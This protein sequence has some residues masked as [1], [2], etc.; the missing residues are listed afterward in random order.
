MFSSHHCWARDRKRAIASTTSCFFPLQ[1]KFDG[2]FLCIFLEIKLY[3]IPVGAGR[4]TD[5]QVVTGLE[6]R[7]THASRRVKS[8]VKP[9]CMFEVGSPEG[10]KKK[11]MRREMFVGWQASTRSLFTVK[12]WRALFYVFHLK[13]P[14]PKV[15]LWCQWNLQTLGKPFCFFCL[16]HYSGLAC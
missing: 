16:V 11:N 12:Q 10:L 7:D 6:Q 14:L 1:K 9:C 4:A 3:H 2:E 5:Q 15:S 8:P 13:V